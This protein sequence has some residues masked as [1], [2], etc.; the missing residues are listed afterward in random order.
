MEGKGK[1]L[2]IRFNEDQTCFV[3]GMENGIRVYTIDPLTRK[4]LIGFDEVGAV[5]HVDMLRRTNLLAFVGGGQAPKFAEKQV[6]IWDDVRKKIILQFN[7]ELPVKSV[8]LYRDGTTGC[9]LAATFQEQICVYRL[10]KEPQLLKT[11]QTASNR[12]G[13]CEICSSSS[14]DLIAFPAPRPGVLAVL[15]SLT[16]GRARHARQEIWAHKSQLA[17]I[18]FNVKGTMVATAS[19][20]GTL[21]RVFDTTTGDKKV[22]FRRGSD[23]ARFH[24]ISFS[25][26]DDYLCASSDK[27]TVHIFALRDQTLNR[28]SRLPNLGLLAQYSASQWGLAQFSVPID[29]MCKCMFTHSNAVIALCDNGTFYRYVFKE[30]GTTTRDGFDVFLDVGFDDDL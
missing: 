13:L 30:S 29:C 7:F 28:K 27:G 25:P 26:S 21:I 9:R 2:D 10:S 15:D 16:L 11:V 24:C 18:S 8:R 5:K 22:E 6:H 12:L 4:T 14:R 1:V 3:C 19:I 23:T 17:C 20:K